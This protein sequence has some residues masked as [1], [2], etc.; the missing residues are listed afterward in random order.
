MAL[1]KRVYPRWP[2]VWRENRAESR[3]LG[4]VE[5]G[6]DEVVAMEE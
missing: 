5:A 1:Y 2:T 6:T 3:R 4:A